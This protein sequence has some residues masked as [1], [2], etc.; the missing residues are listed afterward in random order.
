MIL[1]GLTI[2]NLNVNYDIVLLLQFGRLIDERK[3]KLINILPFSA[4]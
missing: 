3:Q 1:R 2:L 4:L